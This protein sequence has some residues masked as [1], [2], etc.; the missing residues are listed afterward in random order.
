ML[1]YCTHAPLRARQNEY[2]RFS[3]ILHGEVSSTEEQNRAPLHKI[4]E[5]SRGR[6]ERDVAG[7]P[8]PREKN[9]RNVSDLSGQ[10]SE[11]K[12]ASLPLVQGPANQSRDQDSPAC[13]DSSISIGAGGCVNDR[14]CLLD[15]LDRPA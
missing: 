7:R 15:A 3:L 10:N 6:N 1:I 2:V 11:D 9:R 4:L 14:S 8:S 12:T 5:E 13:D